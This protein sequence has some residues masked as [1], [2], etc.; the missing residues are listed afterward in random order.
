MGFLDRAIDSRITRWIFE[1][2]QEIVA[3]VFHLPCKSS[4]SIDWDGWCALDENSIWLVNKQGARGVL[5]KNIEPNSNWGQWPYGSRGFPNYRFEFN[6][7][8]ANGTFTIYPKNAIGGA[9]L[10]QRLERIFGEAN[11]R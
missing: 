5:L 6:F 9:E 7:K 1:Y 4:I 2:T 8:F 3:P 11:E 10:N